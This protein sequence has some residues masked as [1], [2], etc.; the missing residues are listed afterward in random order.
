[1]HGEATRPS[2]VRATPSSACA[3]DAGSA[4]GVVIVVEAEGEVIGMSGVIGVTGVGDVSDV[5][6]VSDVGM[7]PT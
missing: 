1:M 4:G 5:S 6:G 7:W 3:A 2:G